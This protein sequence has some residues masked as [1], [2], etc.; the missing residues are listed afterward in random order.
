MELINRED[1]LKNM[2][3]WQMEFADTGNKRE[4]NLLDMII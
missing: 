3:N 1:F 2:R 4:Y